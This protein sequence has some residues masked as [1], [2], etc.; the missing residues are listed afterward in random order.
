MREVLLEIYREELVE[1]EVKNDEVLVSLKD[2]TE[3]VITFNEI[4]RK[5]DIEFTCCEACEE[6]YEVEYNSRIC[7]DCEEHH[8]EC[9]NCNEIHTNDI[10]YGGDDGSMYCEE[11]YH[12]LF[13]LCE[14]CEREITISTNNYREINGQIL[15]ETCIGNN[16]FECDE[17]GE[18]THYNDCRDDGDHYHCLG[19]YQESPI[20]SWHE[21]NDWRLLG[22]DSN[23]RFGFELEVERHHSDISLKDAASEVIKIM[24]NEI[25]CCY[26]GSLNDGFEI[27]SH[28]M[29]FKHLKSKDDKIKE[30][31]NYL[32]EQGY[33]SHDLNTCGLHVHISREALETEVNSEERTIDNIL[34]IFENFMEELILFSRRNSERIARWSQFLSKYHRHDGEVLT[35][36]FISDG[37]KECGVRYMAVNLQNDH[38]IE[39]RLFRGTLNYKTFMATLQLIY[40]I[41]DYARNNKSIA[42]LTWNKLVMNNKNLKDYSESRNI[43]SKVK[44]SEVIIKFEGKK[45]EPDCISSSDISTNNITTGSWFDE[46]TISSHPTIHYEEYIYMVKYQDRT[47]TGPITAMLRLYVDLM[48]EYIITNG[49]NIIIDRPMFHYNEIANRFELGFAEIRMIIRD[50]CEALEIYRNFEEAFS[51][52][53]RRINNVRNNGET[54]RY[55]FTL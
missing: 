18:L 48:E 41:V 26:D 51:A 3:E 22:E 46:V 39:L 19:C 40:N 2:D 31:L 33:K 32:R 12:D 28:P 44:A 25:V 17:C 24:D 16:Y 1:F 55:T 21:F 23:L 38:T 49:Y 29:T 35:M 14:E 50:E 5:T 45:Q 10:M 7:S 13:F 37:K 11:C 34:M 8:F 20:Y 9:A 42:G 53:E 43:K 52:L 4:K 6:I 27:I 54:Q 36:K 15:C 47:E 30:M